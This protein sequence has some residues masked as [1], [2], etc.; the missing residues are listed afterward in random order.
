MAT[1]VSVGTAEI[2]SRQGNNPGI[3]A[4]T[5]IDKAAAAIMDGM[6]LNQFLAAVRASRI[7][8]G[9]RPWWHRK[10]DKGAKVHAAV[11]PA[12]EVPP[13]PFSPDPDLPKAFA[14]LAPEPD[15]FEGFPG[16]LT[17]AAFPAIA[18]TD[19]PG[20]IPFPPSIPPRSGN[21]PAI[22]NPP[23]PIPE[24]S[25][26]LI[27]ILGLGAVGARLRYARRRSGSV[28]IPVH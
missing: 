26:W 13:A 22:V 20:G 6:G 14:A 4:A 10:G 3:F 28:D 12:P 24:P 16:A 2:I 18:P 21:P 11:A 15:G 1:L 9:E 19:F 7:L 25:T 27:M 23:P 17:P 5:G 8:P